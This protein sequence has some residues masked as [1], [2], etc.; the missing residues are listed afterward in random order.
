MSIPSSFT[1]LAALLLLSSVVS[2]AGCLLEA[3]I[4]SG[5]LIGTTTS[6]PSATATVNKF[7]GIPFADLPPKRFFPPTQ[8]EAWKKPLNVSAWKLACIQQFNCGFADYKVIHASVTN[9]YFLDPAEARALVIQAFN[10]EHPPESEDCLYLNVYA[11]S[12]L[13]PLGGYPVMFWIYGGPLEFGDAEQTAYDG[14]S[15]AAFEDVIVV[16]TNYRANVWIQSD[17]D[18]VID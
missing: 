10:N 2:A 12:S 13:P 3:T 11:P 18:L 14:S 16:T 6:L 1:I 7:L 17:T 15:F 8:T 5:V 9:T 4:T